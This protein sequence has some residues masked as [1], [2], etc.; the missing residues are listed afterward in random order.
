[1]RLR[2]LLILASLLAG[3]LILPASASAK[4]GV[5]RVACN[6]SHQ[7][8]DDPIVFPG[9]PGASHLHQFFG[10]TTTNAFSTLSS[11]RAGSTT[12]KLAGDT[13]GYWF[14]API[15]P[16]G[17]PYQLRQAVAYYSNQPGGGFV[18]TVP[19][20]AQLIGG[21]SAATAPQGVNRVKWDCLADPSVPISPVPITCPRGEELQTTVRFPNCW[22]G[23]GVRRTD[24][25]YGA[26]G[27]TCPSGYTAIPHIR[28][29]FEWNR[30]NATGFH[31]SSGS[32]NS[33]HA[34]FWN[35]WDQSVLDA[36]LRAAGVIA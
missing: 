30:S 32:L 14:P 5:L 27:N 26:K 15:G 17:Q 22:D 9:Q 28:V 7:A 21:N 34:D 25:T 6:F 10:N 36:Q 1:M 18:H 23:S 11:M 2:I 24:F 13:A 29:S 35:T 20:G 4:A 8:S 33:A 19:A 12:C 3:V 31:L 16:S